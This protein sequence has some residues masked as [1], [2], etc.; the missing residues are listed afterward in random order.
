MALKLFSQHPGITAVFAANDVIAYGVLQAAAET[1]KSIPQDI[2]L[3]GYD[4]LDFSALVHPPLTTIHQPKYE[5]GRA[6]VELLL[7][8]IRGH[9]TTF[10]EHQV[11]GVTLV[12]RQSCRKRFPKLGQQKPFATPVPAP[13]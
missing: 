13:A 6:A 2:S 3:I 11:F 7:R 1:G 8:Q 5:I 12:E 9:S 4:N 10:P